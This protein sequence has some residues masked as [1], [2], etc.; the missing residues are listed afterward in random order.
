MRLFALVALLMP[1]LVQAQGAAIENPLKAKDI[2]A[3]L[4]AFLGGVVQLGSIALLLALIWTGF[5]FAAAQG[6]QEAIQKARTTLVWTVV[7]GLILLGA[8][9]IKNVLT[10]T[11]QSLS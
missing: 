11:V 1:S 4:A 8:E 5:Q 9:L 6:N 3:L 2:E 7:G 10:A